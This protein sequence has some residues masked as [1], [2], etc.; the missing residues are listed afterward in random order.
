MVRLSDNDWLAINNLLLKMYSDYGCK[1][2]DNSLIKNLQY[3]IPF[4]YASL[5]IQNY[6]TGPSL[7]NPEGYGFENGILEQK[8][9]YINIATPHRWVNFD[10]RCQVVR[11]SD[12]YNPEELLHLEY[13]QELFQKYRIRHELT[14]SL[15]HK[16]HRVGVLTLFR[17]ENDYDFTDREVTI[18]NHLIDHI[19]CYIHQNYDFDQYFMEIVENKNKYDIEFLTEK[20]LLTQRESEVLSAILEGM[21][22]RAIADNLCLSET[23]VKKHSHSIYEK[24]NIAGKSDLFKIVLEKQ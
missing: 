18:A 2:F 19:A 17:C 5:Y 23:T 15:A 6:E 7:Y 11:I 16:R 21:S 24:L 1:L 13:Y 4:K 14:F 10:E 12:I 20:Y 22:I 8:Q 3:L 9:E